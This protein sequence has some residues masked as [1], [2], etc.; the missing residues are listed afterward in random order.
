MNNTVTDFVVYSFIVAGIFLMTKP[1]G[2][3]PALVSSLTNG[4]ANIAK[5]VTGQG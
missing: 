5:A 3:G 4:Y 2:Q 1:G